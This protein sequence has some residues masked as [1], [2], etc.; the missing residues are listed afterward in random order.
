MLNVYSSFLVSTFISGTFGSPKDRECWK[1][2]ITRKIWNMM[3]TR[4]GEQQKPRAIR[5]NCPQT[6]LTQPSMS[7]QN[8]PASAWRI[9]F[10][11]YETREETGLGGEE[12]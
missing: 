9:I 3:K 6:V 10:S 4:N 5:S 11:N 1:I 2:R 7:C 8:K 12:E